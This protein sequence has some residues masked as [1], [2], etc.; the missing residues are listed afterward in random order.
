MSA[1]LHWRQ[2][3]SYAI[4]HYVIP[5]A[6]KELVKA[7]V[8]PLHGAWKQSFSCH[9]LRHCIPTIR[10][11]ISHMTID[12]AMIELMSRQ[13]TRD[14]T[15]GKNEMEAR[16]QQLEAECA[17]KERQVQENRLKCEA[18]EKREH[19]RRDA[20]AKKHKEEVRKGCEIGFLRKQRSARRRCKGCEAGCVFHIVIPGIQSGPKIKPYKEEACKQSVRL[21]LCSDNP[22]PDLYKNC[23]RSMELTKRRWAIAE[24]RRS[25]LILA[26][27]QGPA[28]ASEVLSKSVHAGFEA[29][30]VG[31]AQFVPLCL[32]ADNFFWQPKQA[33][34]AM[35]LLFNSE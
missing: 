6:G 11:Q 10:A 23:V 8:R 20:E 13:E 1:R 18:I 3:T 28:G 33:G 22:L 31:C 21:G 12:H 24:V 15:R 5:T 17:E 26:Y 25:P 4:K 7:F 14:G 16:I 2:A 19:E 27:L 9:C 29:Y 32:C 34:K 35:L 30:G